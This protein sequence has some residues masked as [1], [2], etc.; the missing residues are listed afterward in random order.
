MCVCVCVITYIVLLERHFTIVLTALYNSTL[1]KV[2]HF[3]IQ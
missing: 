2:Y 1:L 3:S